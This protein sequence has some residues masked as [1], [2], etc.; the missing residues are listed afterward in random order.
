MISWEEF[1][2]VIFPELGRKS[3]NKAVKRGSVVTNSSSES[4]IRKPLNIEAEDPIRRWGI[5]RNIREKEVERALSWDSDDSIPLPT[6][7]GEDRSVP[8][9]RG[10]VVSFSVSTSSELLSSFDKALSSQSERISRTAYPG[11]EIRE[12]SY[13]RSERYLLFDSRIFCY[14]EY[15]VVLFENEYMT[16][17]V[18]MIDINIIFNCFYDR[19][20]VSV[21]DEEKGGDLEGG[22]TMLADCHMDAIKEGEGGE[23]EEDDRHL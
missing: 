7:S 23:E 8:E 1:S 13:S 6:S 15:T 12:C 2:S 22:G 19:N 9:H 4:L 18:D 21:N 17:C 11:S 3:T 10:R 14:R 5:D 20:D 16:F